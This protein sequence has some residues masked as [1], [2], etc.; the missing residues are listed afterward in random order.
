MQLVDLDKALD[1]QITLKVRQNV[2]FKTEC[3]P[4]EIEF[5]D[6]DAVDEDGFYFRYQGSISHFHTQ[7]STDLFSVFK[8]WWYW[9]LFSQT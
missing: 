4:H 7:F 3:D 1:V 6:G 9:N 5:V 8:V 2:A